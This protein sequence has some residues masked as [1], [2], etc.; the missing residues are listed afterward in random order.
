MIQNL[1]ELFSKKSQSHCQEQTVFLA[2]R[3]CQRWTQ[4]LSEDTIFL[5][6]KITISSVKTDIKSQGRPL[7]GYQWGVMLGRGNHT[8]SLCSAAS[9]IKHQRSTKLIH[10]LCNKQC[11]MSYFF[12]YTRNLKKIINSLKPNCCNA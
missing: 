8:D 4:G 9:Y 5:R 6:L 10:N 3:V 1:W 12:T 2:G 7:K 11:F